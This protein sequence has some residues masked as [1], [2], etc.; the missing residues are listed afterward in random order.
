MSG[1]TRSRLRLGWHLDRPSEKLEIDAMEISRHCAV[2][3]QSGGGKSFL[4]ARLLEE[5]LL[6]T[7]ARVVVLD[8]NGDMRQ[9]SEVGT[10]A[11][12]PT[13]RRWDRLPEN[14]YDSSASFKS[15]W[16]SIRK[17]HI[18]LDVEGRVDR[19]GAVWLRPALDWYSVDSGWRAEALGLELGRDYGEFAVLRAAED[20]VQQSLGSAG[21]VRLP[22][23]ADEIERRVRVGEIGT[24]QLGHVASLLARLNPVAASGLWS[25]DHRTTDL[26]R[27]IA[28]E[29]EPWDLL[30]LDLPCVRNPRVRM[31]LVAY[32]LEEL[33]DAAREDW[34]AALAD[35]EGAW[36]VPTIVVIDECQNFAPAG[37]PGNPIADRVLE[38]ILRIA[39]EGRKYGLFL[40]LATQRPSKVRRGLLTECENV[41]LLRLNSPVE[42]QI[43]A[44]TWGMPLSDVA[45]TKYFEVGDGLLFGRWSP[46]P[47]AFH[48]A[49]RRTR[50]GGAGLDESTWTKP[51][52]SK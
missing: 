19:P 20:A 48:S 16:E 39:A 36:R 45:R 14:D 46:A 52:T 29:G 31:H 38:S 26:S 44:E 43:A 7:Q 8:T 42:H 24:G 18:T 40:L 50:E 4:L 17:V 6:C 51:R 11:W 32:A 25:E 30:V 34:E 3:A 9:V 13:A 21:Q 5:A 27:V 22:T 15:D 47:V 1:K 23:V 2:L 37:S 49:F 33:W 35:P 10:Q 41:C 12:A 28:R